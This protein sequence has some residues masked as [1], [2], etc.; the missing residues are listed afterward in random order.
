[1][2]RFLFLQHHF[3]H[4]DAC[5]YVCVR[6]NSGH[7]EGN[8]GERGLKTAVKKYVALYMGNVGVRVKAE[9][10]KRALTLKKRSGSA[11]RLWV[12]RGQT[13]LVA[14]NYL[15]ED[16]LPTESLRFTSWILS[17]GLGIRSEERRVGK[18]CRSRWS[19]Y[20]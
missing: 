6:K 14:N 13:D 9:E 1:M 10:S 3:V 11:W 16:S 20:H 15:E 12:L 19:P 4:D 18:E 7:Q 2:L 8:S 17:G 5:V